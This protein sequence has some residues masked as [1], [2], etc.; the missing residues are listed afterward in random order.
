MRRVWRSGG[1]TLIE[2]IVVIGVLAVPATIGTIMLSR[3]TDAWRTESARSDL[4]ARAEYVFSQMRQ[5]VSSAVSAGVSGSAIKGMVQTAE[6]E[7]Y[8]RVPLEDDR[9][10]IPAMLPAADGT[11]QRADVG[12]YV[13]RED[14]ECRLMRTVR[15]SGATDSVPQPVAAGVLAMRVEYAG[16]QGWQEG[17]SSGINPDAV[18]VSLVLLSA[19]RP[20]EQ[21]VRSSVFPVHVN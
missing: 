15:V 1:F 4:S 7:R 12:Y 11:P 14:G 2:L 10:F 13:D 6:D 18:R 20:W 16:G 17:W 3:I 8:H 5:D 21:V 9:F 19:D